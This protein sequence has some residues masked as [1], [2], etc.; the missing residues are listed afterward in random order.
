MFKKYVQKRLEKYVRKY[1]QTHPEVKLVVVAG[2][3]GKTTTKTMIATLLSQR[4][5]VGMDDSNHN[6][7]LSA[8]LGILGISYPENPRSISQWLQVFSACKKR[9][10]QPATVDVLIQELG[11]D[12]VGDIAHFG[13]YLRPHIAV[14]AAVTPEH[15]EFFGTIE[16]VAEEELAVTNYSELSL[17]NR[18]DIDGR[19]AN[20]ITNPNIATFGTTSA[21]EYRFETDDFSIENGYSGRIIAPELAQPIPASVRVLGEHSLRPV[22]AAV[23]TALRLGLSA[24]E[25]VNGL[26]EV[27]AV[28]GRMNVLPGLKSSIIIDDTYNSSPAAV[29]SALQTLYSMQAPQRIAILGSMNELGV[30]SEAEHRKVG[31]MCDPG[32]LAWV[33][34]VGEDAEKW[35]AS[36]AKFRG[37]QVRSFQNPIDAGAFA[38]S[39]LE[40]NAIVLVKGSQGGIFCEEAVKILLQHTSDDSKLVRQSPEWMETKRSF[41]E[42]L[43]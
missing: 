20:F 15:M 7:H 27:R 23:A 32:L 43:K 10:K 1:F 21:A 19:F 31:E 25:V 11:T 9:I 12:T 35:I 40:E 26:A 2:S 22:M 13:T 3:V 24:Q 28:A 33:V 17:I 5:R 6:T 36:V 38:N 18:D 4:L 29:A 42:K 8:P 41:L 14:V 30:S 16:R 37:C 34:T 39:V